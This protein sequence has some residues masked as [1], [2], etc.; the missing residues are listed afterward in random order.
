MRPQHTQPFPPPAAQQ[1]LAEAAAREGIKGVRIG[2][3]NYVGKSA[4]AVAGMQQRERDL[5]DK[6]AQ[7]LQ[8]KRQRD[9]AAS[10]K[11]SA[12]AAAAARHGARLT[13]WAEDHG[14][15]RALRALLAS[16]HTVLWPGARWRA[17]GLGDLLQP[18][19][20]R[21]AYLR[22]MM[23]V[24]ED[25]VVDLPPEH[26]YIANRACEGLTEAYKIFT[27]AELS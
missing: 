5:A 6:T 3:R 11:A 26:Q 12:Y 10:D 14:K 17:V 18:P 24:H 22:S 2:D 1:A 27:E 16:L 4:A 8:E 7:A 25:K 15:K 19:A 21:R 23:V 9:Q 13:A 20:V